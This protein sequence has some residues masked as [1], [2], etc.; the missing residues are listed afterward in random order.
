MIFIFINLII[1]IVLIFLFYLLIQG[2]I[3]YPSNDLAIKNMLKLT[4]LKKGD[5]VA[6]LGSGDGRV[7]IAF[8]K[9]GAI[10][11]GFEINPLLVLIS[12][13]NVNKHRLSGSVKIFW[14]SFWGVNLS[15][16]KTVTVFGIDYIMQKLKNKLTRELLPGSIILVNIFPFPDWKPDKKT[17]GVFLY[18]I[19]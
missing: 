10:V 2:A 8:A 3:Y 4:K 1:I 15:G 16:Y 13:Y 18:K 9:K 19:K 11:S 5:L 7:T 17:K 12:R 6:D 14:K